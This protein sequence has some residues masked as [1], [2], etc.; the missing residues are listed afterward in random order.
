MSYFCHVPKC[1]HQLTIHN[2]EIIS[3]FSVLF[4]TCSIN[5][6]LKRILENVKYCAHY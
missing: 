5:Q 4:I 6:T 3:T 1:E 2:T